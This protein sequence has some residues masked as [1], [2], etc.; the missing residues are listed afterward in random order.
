VLACIRSNSAVSSTGTHLTRQVDGQPEVRG[1]Q[2]DQ[3]RPVLELM[4]EGLTNAG[5]AKRL[6]VSE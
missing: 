2:P 4:A 3:E 6:Y 1:D 5:I